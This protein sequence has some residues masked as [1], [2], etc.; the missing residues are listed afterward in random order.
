MATI[1]IIIN[2]SKNI[3]LPRC[4]RADSSVISKK[5]MLHVQTIK[6]P[7][8]IPSIWALAIVYYS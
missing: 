4:R 7:S 8:H 3:S 6:F 1:Q 5:I 2:S